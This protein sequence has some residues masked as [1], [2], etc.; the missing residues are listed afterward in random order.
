M[1]KVASKVELRW[2]VAQSR[3]LSVEQRRRLLDKLS[4]RLTTQGELIVVAQRTRDQ[5]KNRQ[6]ALVKLVQGLRKALAP[7]KVRKPT[8]ITRGAKER[9]LKA[10]RER[11]EVK[12]GRRRLDS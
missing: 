5:A 11:A 3:A 6:E 10:K 8:R 2:S 7:V 4:H 9:R 1:N 12:G